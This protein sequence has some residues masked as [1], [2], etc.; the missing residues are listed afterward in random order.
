VALHSIAPCVTF[1]HMMDH[2]AGRD[3]KVQR[4]L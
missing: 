4:D 2:A 1:I 3:K